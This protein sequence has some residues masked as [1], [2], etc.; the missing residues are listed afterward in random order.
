MLGTT[1]PGIRDHIWKEIITG[2]ETIGFE[3]LAANILTR[4]I[5]ELY[6]NEPSVENLQRYTLQLRELFV[7]NSEIPSAKKDID[8]IT[9]SLSDNQ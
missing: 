2:K 9:G 7:R 5:R 3:F 6:I 1:I 8:K 4:R